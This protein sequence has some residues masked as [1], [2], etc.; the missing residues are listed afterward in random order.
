MPW[1]LTPIENR[2]DILRGGLVPA[3]GPRSELV[4]E[5]RPLVHLFSTFEDLESADWLWD[6]FED[7][8]L[9]LFHVDVPPED[10]AWTEIA[11][12][13]GAEQL[14]LVSADFDEITFGG[15]AALRALDKVAAPF[16]DLESFRATRTEMKASDFGTLVGD[17]LWEEDDDSKFLVYAA[18]YWIEV[19][20]DGRHMLT[21]ENLGWLT[22]HDGE[23]LETLEERLFDFTRELRDPC[24][25]PGLGF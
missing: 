13:I 17:T 25:E 22:G 9:A 20:E 14:R 23:T 3:I 6:H 18:G 16:T 8:P 19:I 21:L 12:T 2:F 11:E 10:G 15:Y 5:E 4:S 24:V 1:H 7:E